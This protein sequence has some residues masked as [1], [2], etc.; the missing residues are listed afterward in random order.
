MRERFGGE[1]VI[2]PT[3]L[4]TYVACPFRFLLEDVLHLE[5]LEEPGEDIEASDRGLVFH[6]TLAWLH[7][8]L[9]EHG[10]HG[11]TADVDRLIREQLDEEVRKHSGH[12]SR[13]ARALWQIEGRALQRRRA[14]PRRLGEVR[15]DVGRAGGGAA[16]GAPGKGFGTT[17]VERRA[18]PP[19]VTTLTTLVP[20]GMWVCRFEPLART[21]SGGENHV[22][23]GEGVAV[24]EFHALAQDG[25]ASGSAPAFPSFSASAGMIFRS[26]SRA[27]RPSIDMA[28][29]G[30]GGA[31]VERIGIERFE[32]ALVGV[33]QGLGR[34]RR[35]A[36]ATDGGRGRCKQTLTYRHLFGFPRSDQPLPQ[37]AADIADAMLP[38]FSRRA[39]V[40]FPHRPCRFARRCGND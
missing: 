2:S 10:I 26:L 3:A 24:L 11:P 34:C 23:G 15:C 40:D 8:Y 36:K 22:V 6:R 12:A 35:H 31:L 16:A 14:L 9:K 33:A 21:R 17:P 29:M 20:L 39:S 13:A 30:V 37:L 27:I 5:P 25:S 4:E 19:L 7:R 32:I 18:V 28:E 38:E 1:K